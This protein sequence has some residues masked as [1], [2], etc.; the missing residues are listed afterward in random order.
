MTGCQ[1]DDNVVPVV[2]VPY[3]EK[4][5]EL[6][7]RWSQLKQI[8]LVVIKFMLVRDSDKVWII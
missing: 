1:L 4:S 6:A 7:C 8:Q 2:A 5:Y 3:S